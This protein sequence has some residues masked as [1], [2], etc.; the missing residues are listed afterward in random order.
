M[1]LFGSNVTASTQQVTA[2]TQMG[3]G[4]NDAMY[5][6]FL[7]IASNGSGA[8]TVTLKNGASGGTTL[9]TASTSGASTQKNYDFGPSGMLFPSGCYLTTGANISYATICYSH[10]APC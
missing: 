2:S 10:I 6:Y 7:H 8:T 1:S 3:E 9:L 5:V 4:L